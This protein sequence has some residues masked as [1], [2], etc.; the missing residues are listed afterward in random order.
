MWALIV[1]SQAV[2][3]E[4]Y[5]GKKVLFINSYHAGYEWSDGI[6]K[7]LESGFKGTGI[8]LEKFYMDT[9]RK[10]A[11]AEIIAAA[12]QAIEKIES[13][14]PDLVITADDNA[15][16]YVIVPLRKNTTLP[17][18]FTG[19]NW[20]ATDYGFPAENVTGM[21]ETA[22]IKPIVKNLKEYAQGETIGLLSIDAISG[23]K[24]AKHFERQLGHPFERIYYVKNFAKWKESY[25]KLQQ[26]V[27]MM[28]LENPKGI[29]GWDNHLG[30]QF[31]EQH[32]RI[33]SGTTHVWLSPYALLTIAKI[34]QEQG[35]WAA[36]TALK[37]LN[38]AKPA[39]IAM[40][41]NKKGKLFINFRLAKPQG[42]VFKPA[43][44]KTATILR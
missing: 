22:L 39:D 7:G 30:Q 42:I 41:K 35:Q 25:I 10:R 34:P 32:T 28:I 36:Q 14:K 5:K 40:V 4:Q 16:K 15:A 43:L 31:V 2:C 26:E 17:F 38:G 29:S 3:A 33:P 20:D 23:H 1:V 19:V 24:N 18:I 9:K 11:K 21:V 37:I 44:I 6:E 13:F 12:K 8:E 27:D